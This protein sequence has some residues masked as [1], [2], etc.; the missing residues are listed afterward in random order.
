MKKLLLTALAVG[1]TNM[2]FFA[3][4][5]PLYYNAAVEAQKSS[6]P[7]AVKGYP[8]ASFALIMIVALSVLFALALEHFKAD[9]LRKGIQYGASILGGLFFV[10][11]M[12]MLGMYNLIDLNFAITDTI[13]SA[14]MGGIMGAVGVSVMRRMA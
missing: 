1:V 9:S 14:V 2:A 8:E 4:G 3:L 5:G 7:D 13:I 11:N 10:M 12:Q 6:F